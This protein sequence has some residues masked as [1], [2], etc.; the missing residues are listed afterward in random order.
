MEHFEIKT[1]R[2]LRR[3]KL[4]IANEGVVDY[5]RSVFA[6]HKPVSQAQAVAEINKLFYS[7]NPAEGLRAYFAKTLGDESWVAARLSDKPRTQTCIFANISGAPTKD[8]KKLTQCLSGPMM[9]TALDVINKSKPNT[10]VRLKA[11]KELKAAKSADEYDSIY[12]KYKGQLKATNMDSQ[13]WLKKGGKNI[14]AVGCGDV[15]WPV[16]KDDFYNWPN[17][18]QA[19]SNVEGPTKDNRKEWESQIFALAAV[20]TAAKAHVEKNHLP[21]Y[22]ELN[23]DFLDGCTYEDEITHDIC[24]NL[25]SS[26]GTN[27][28]PMEYV[29]FAA[30]DLIVELLVA[31][32]K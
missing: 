31:L 1:D 22:E 11:F 26:D 17:Y 30:R 18:S 24:I 25:S 28:T 3:E 29:M 9:A 27:V 16:D 10:E 21:D 4:E 7:K 6:K 12:E 20:F 14:P 13:N 32:V 19:K 2:Q 5:I 15:D 8:I 23:Y